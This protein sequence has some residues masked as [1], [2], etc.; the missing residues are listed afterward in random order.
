MLTN[1]RSIVERQSL[2][3]SGENE[4]TFW[5]HCQT[6]DRGSLHDRFWTLQLSSPLQ[7]NGQSGVCS[8]NLSGSSYVQTQPGQREWRQQERDEE[9][10]FENWSRIE[11]ATEVACF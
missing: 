1:K 6:T 7:S 4:D 5:H 8:L 10:L 11:G 2:S 3:K 9:P